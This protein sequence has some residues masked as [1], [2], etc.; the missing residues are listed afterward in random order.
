VRAH[1]AVAFLLGR[2]LEQDGHCS[3][4]MARG[5][6]MRVLD[7]VNVRSLASF[8]VHGSDALDSRMGSC[9]WDLSLGQHTGDGN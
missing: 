2:L 9:L 7:G 8:G 6:E 3:R 4:A 5:F 1:V